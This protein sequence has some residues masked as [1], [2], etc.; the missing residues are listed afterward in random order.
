ML[1]NF[2]LF[3]ELAIKAYSILLVEMNGLSPLKATL[4]A[5]QILFYLFLLRNSAT[6]SIKI[7][8]ITFTLGQS[9]YI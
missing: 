6:L 2:S 5:I 3:L 1:L 7:Q 9:Y 4:R 8:N